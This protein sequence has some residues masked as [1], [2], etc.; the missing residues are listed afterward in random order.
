MKFECEASCGFLGCADMRAILADR[1]KLHRQGLRRV[2]KDAKNAPVR[3]VAKDAKDASKTQIFSRTPRQRQV[4]QWKR[5]EAEM[6]D[7]SAVC[8]PWRSIFAALGFH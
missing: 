5:W 2:A 1:P 7:E 8:H 6:P 4:R 3:R